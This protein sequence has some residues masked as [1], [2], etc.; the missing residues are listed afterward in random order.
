MTTFGVFCIG[1][2]VFSLLTLSASH[3]AYIYG[4]TASVLFAW[5]EWA[6]RRHMKGIEEA[7]ERSEVVVDELE[8][9]GS[10]SVMRILTLQ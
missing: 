5:C 10:R 1:G 3:P 4:V 6:M 2:A 7:F 9:I 8:K